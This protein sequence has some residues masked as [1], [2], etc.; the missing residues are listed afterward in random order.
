M[1]GLV[2]ASLSVLDFRRRTAGL[3][4][5]PP[6]DAIHVFAC[7]ITDVDA[8]N[9]PALDA[10]SGHEAIRSKAQFPRMP[11]GDRAS[12]GR[13]A[14]ADLPENRHRLLDEKVD[15]VAGTFG[16]ERAQAPQES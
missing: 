10:R 11:A 6:S 1:A 12:F 8:R 16:A 4:A 7:R 13:M 5:T 14:H 2:A 3:R 15:H 9:K